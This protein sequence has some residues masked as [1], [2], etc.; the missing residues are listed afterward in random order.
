M[1]HEVLVPRNLVQ[2]RVQNEYPEELESRHPSSKKKERKRFFSCDSLLN[3]VALDGH[4]KRC[5]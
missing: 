5:G 1:Q 4:K 2:K 3:V